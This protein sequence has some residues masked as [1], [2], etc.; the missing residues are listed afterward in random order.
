MVNIHPRPDPPELSRPALQ[1]RRA[2]VERIR[3]A[4]RLASRVI[5]PFR[6][7]TVRYDEKEE[8]GPVTAADR[9]LD[10][11]L[12]E[13][14]PRRGEGWL[15]EETRD[16]R[17]RVSVHRVWVVD[18]LDGTKE[19]V[20]G[21][22]EWCVSVGLV[23]AGV[24]VAGGILNPATRETIVGSIETGVT[25]NGEPVAVRERRT[26]RGAT[27]LASRSEISRG[28][29]DRWEDAP[30]EVVPS[31]SVAYK[32]AR[33]AAGFADATW[34]LVPKHEWDVAAG[35]ALVRA[36]GGVAVHVDGTEPT[37]NRPDTRF[38]NL[39]AGSEGPIRELREEHLS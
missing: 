5:R 13:T 3:S 36:A 8:G 19:F 26:L 39:L 1:D 25:R 37:F 31:G 9:E 32:L 21:I 35:V 34:T 2:D 15:S 28:E 30:F 6:S 4:L 24:P 38:P 20:A 7:G 11:A 10:A 29:W 22:P 33:V 27:V 18:P 14:L 16:N 17:S 23:E 12:R